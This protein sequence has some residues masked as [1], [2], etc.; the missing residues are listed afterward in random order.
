MKKLCALLLFLC[1]FATCAY[2][3][4]ETEERLTLL[5]NN[6]LKT[7]LRNNGYDGW[8][9]YQPGSR[10]EDINTS[11]NP[12]LKEIDVY[13]VLA[14]REEQ[15]HLIILQKRNKNWMIQTV[16]DKAI[17]R[18]GFR[19][20]DF[21]MD[22]N[23]SSDAVTL[24]VY[25]DFADAD[26]RTYTLNLELSQRFPSFFR[27]LDLPGEDSGSGRISRMIVMNYLRDFDFELDLFGGAFRERIGV[28]PWQPYEFGVE[29]FVLADMP[30]SIGDLTKP[31]Y[32]KASPDGVGL[33]RYPMETEKPIKILHEGDTVNIVRLE[34]GYENWMIVCVQDDVYF[35][36]SELIEYE[37]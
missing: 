33:Y 12:F 2:A 22:E 30:L 10:E 3:S 27:F 36:R 16:N 15:I 4:T 20:Y 11:S 9:L 17:V 7:L 21:S 29:E 5:S 34:Y 19:L 18:D 14:M 26:D 8:L 23:I 24:Y 37:D 25:F 31:A 32:V 6:K 35:V 1:L 13:P 28:M